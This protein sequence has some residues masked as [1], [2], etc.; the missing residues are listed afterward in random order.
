MIFSFDVFQQIF[1]EKQQIFK[2]AFRVH[3]SLAQKMFGIFISI[4]PTC[5][6]F[7]GKSA[8]KNPY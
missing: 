8:Q 5:P 1:F 2:S 6:G 7:L 3:V 4:N